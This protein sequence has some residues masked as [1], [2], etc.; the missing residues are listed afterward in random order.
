MPIHSALPSVQH[1]LVVVLFGLN[2]SLVLQLC[3][4]RSS[5]FIHNL[6]KLASHGAITLTNLS[7]HISLVHLL[8][9]AS[10]HHLVLVSLVLTLNLS[11]H[12]LALVLLHPLLLILQLLLKLDV[13]LSISVHVSQQ[14]DA[15][16]VFTVPLLL[17]GLPLFGVLLSD[18]PVDHLLVDL[19]VLALLKGKLLKLDCLS[20][21]AHTFIILKLLESLLALKCR[22]QKLQISLFLRKFSL[23]S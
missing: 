11:L 12:V 17:A 22:V 5:L 19:L 20:T 23:L 7:Q 21:V 18:K 10:L 6:L 3:Q 1:L 8:H 13:L 4:L 14:V 15:G 2:A 16:L 9:H